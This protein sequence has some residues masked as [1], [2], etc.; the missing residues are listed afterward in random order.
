MRIFINMPTHAYFSN[1]TSPYIV[2]LLTALFIYFVGTYILINEYY[3]YWRGNRNFQLELYCLSE[4]CTL[5]CMYIQYIT[6]TYRYTW[7]QIVGIAIIDCEF[8]SRT[9]EIKMNNFQRINTFNREIIARRSICVYMH[10]YTYIHVWNERRKSMNHLNVL[11]HT[12]RHWIVT[13][14]SLT[15][16][17]RSCNAGV[18]L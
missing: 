3:Y 17:G 10:M 8:F 11:A 15:K 4:K 5:L 1:F 7:S 18:N 6:R 9:N 12:F 14:R 16:I 2:I 13:S